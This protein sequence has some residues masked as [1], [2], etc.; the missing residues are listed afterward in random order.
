MNKTLALALTLTFSTLAFAKTTSVYTDMK[1]DCIV[2]SSATDQAPID[3]YSSECK[4]FGGFKLQEEGSDL[5]Y[6]PSLSFNQKEIDLQIPYSFHEM[7][8]NKM[9]WVYDLTQDKEGSGV[10][11]F[12]ALIFRINSDVESDNGDSKSVSTLHV[13][14]LNGEKSCII[15]LVST[16]E[17]ARALANKTD[18]ACSAPKND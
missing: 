11:T 14:R 18:A 16:N 12:K 5:R 6:H 3:F 13:V 4:A 15:G 9:E 1:Q 8:S 7:G 10:L 2:V 17:E